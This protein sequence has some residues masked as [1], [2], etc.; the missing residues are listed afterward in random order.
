MLKPTVTTGCVLGVAEGLHAATYNPDETADFLL[1]PNMDP[2]VGDRI[3][4]WR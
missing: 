1:L 4:L 2:Q 3:Q